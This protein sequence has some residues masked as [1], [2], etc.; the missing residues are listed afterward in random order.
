MILES[1]SSSLLN[2]DQEEGQCDFIDL[3]GI[4]YNVIIQRKQ[5]LPQCH[6]R[7]AQ[8]NSNGYL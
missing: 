6:L 2:I 4:N 3:Q 1:V 8:K 5:G 7:K